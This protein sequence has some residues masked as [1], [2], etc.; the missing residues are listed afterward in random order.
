VGVVFLILIPWSYVVANYGKKPGD[1]W[2]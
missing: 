2:R 1:R